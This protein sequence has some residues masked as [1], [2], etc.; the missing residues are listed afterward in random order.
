[1][2]SFY[3]LA[4]ASR[5]DPSRRGE[6]DHFV[7]QFVAFQQL[8][9]PF[10]RAQRELSAVAA[11]VPKLEGAFAQLEATLQANSVAS[12]Q[13][14][15]ALGEALAA[16]DIELEVA[17]AEQLAAAE[18]LAQSEARLTELEAAFQ[19]NSAASQQREQ[20]LGDALAARDIEIEV[21]RTEQLAAA[22]R[23]TQSE[24]R[25]AE[26]GSANKRWTRHWRRAT[27][28]SKRRE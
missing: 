27:A 11:R 24:A 7:N 10:E 18:R 16:R 17:R 28:K 19:A 1:M 25:L 12:Q 20:A 22:E 2:R 14:E 8:L 15:Q 5:K 4:A 13:R 23:L 26:V 6:I 9:W 3:N 21:A